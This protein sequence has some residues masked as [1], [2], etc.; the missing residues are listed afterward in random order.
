[1]TMKKLIGI[2]I[3]VFAMQTGR[4]NT[5]D[6]PTKFQSC[7][8]VYNDLIAAIGT[9]YPSP[10]VFVPKNSK[11]LTA[12]TLSNGEI[13]I[14]SF[15]IDLCREFGPDSLN[16]MALI[17]GHE[18][19]HH[20]KEHFWAAEYGSDFANLSWG[21]KIKE[22]FKDQRFLETYESQADEFGIFYS[23][24][25]GYNTFEI[26]EKV[27]KRIYEAY[28][29]PD[30][31][32][33]YPSLQDRIKIHQ[34]SEEKLNKLIPI[35]ESGNLLLVLGSNSKNK[36]RKVILEKAAEC[37]QSIIDENYTNKEIYNNIGI[38]HLMLALSKINK[39]ENKFLYPVTMDT[40][41]RLYN[42][43]GSNAT[44]T[45]TSGFGENDAYI[46]K[47]L[48]LA[49]RYF[50]RAKE[51]DKN[52][53]P[54]YIN[55]S[56]VYDLT[57]EFEDAIFFAGKAITKSEKENND[58]LKANG[59]LIKGLA[60]IHNNEL[61]TGIDDLTKAKNLGNLIAQTNLDVIIP[62]EKKE[63]PIHK[64]T[65]AFG[66]RKELIGDKSLEQVFEETN[67]EWYNKDYLFKLKDGSRLYKFSENDGDLFI[68]ECD[69]RE[70][71]FQNLVFYQVKENSNAVTGRNIRIS[72]PE[73]EVL[74]VYGK[75]TSTISSINFLYLIYD[76]L[77][78]M[79]KIKPG[80]GV[81]NWANYMYLQ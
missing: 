42:V 27:F 54:A 64:K 10:P 74:K 60:N 16:A 34:L 20:Y 58:M 25:A 79:F 38:A 12:K 46:L 28:R 61:Q 21:K 49:E 29:L 65:L 48:N 55:L 50:N 39:N 43:E 68:I 56:I 78:I 70:C 11:T 33:G 80:K 17:L 13:H 23:F 36:E 24:I 18:L 41:S 71:V 32:P 37:F 15:F 52:Y 69:E 72:S 1:M 44:G 47:H 3:L 19:A 76:D 81:V 73:E 59:L 77:G 40:E 66:I 51:A 8:Q 5:T 45:K 9:L 67:N 30:T 57:G 7:N 75:P 6:I 31:I 62:N 63:E 26:A 53:I 22:N 14:G 2:I 4:G 35:F